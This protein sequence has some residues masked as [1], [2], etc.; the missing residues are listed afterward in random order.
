MSDNP[1]I[2]IWPGSNK[3]AFDADRTFELLVFQE[4][5]CSSEE[6]MTFGDA[7]DALVSS[8]FLFD[9]DYP[10]HIQVVW[11]FLVEAMYKLPLERMCHKWHKDKK[12][13]TVTFQKLLNYT[14]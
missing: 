13:S 6:G 4:V 8:I 9:I 10:P 2:R 12:K 1:V 7:V 5:L 11:R 3:S 14:L